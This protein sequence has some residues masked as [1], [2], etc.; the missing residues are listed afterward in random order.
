MVVGLVDQDQ[1]DRQLVLLC[2]HH[3]PILALDSGMDRG[4][5]K[6]RGTLDLELDLEL[7]LVKMKSRH[8]SP[9]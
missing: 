2:L 7:E 8:S 5:L 1:Q 4:L 3:L 6:H 9:V